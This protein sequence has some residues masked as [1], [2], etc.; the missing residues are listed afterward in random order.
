MFF[1]DE[2]SSSAGGSNNNKNDDGDGGDNGG[3]KSHPPP[4]PIFSNKSSS[5][6][7]E[8]SSFGAL[9]NIAVPDNYPT[10][11]IIP[12]Y[13]NPVFPKFVK[14]VEVSIILGTKYFDPICYPFQASANANCL[15]LRF[16]SY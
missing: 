4:P 6:Y 11:P 1:S 9:A 14:L 3:N 10:V 2:G 15:N 16:L 8:S 13:R 12:L 7:P 5:N